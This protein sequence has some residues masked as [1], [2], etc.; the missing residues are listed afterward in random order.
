[1][2]D[3]LSELT[4]RLN[5]VLAEET[6]LLDA[7]DLAAA[8]NLLPRK[9]DAVAAL[10]SAIIAGVHTADLDERQMDALRGRAQRLTELGE[11]NRQ[12]IE[13]G[14]AL[15]TQLIQTIAQ[16]V[17]KAR[18]GEAPVYQADGTKIPPRPPESY[19]FQRQ[20]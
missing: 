6:G 7:L 8:T 13:R 12:A 15:Q 16:A 19:A 2:S 20:M 17:P 14:L 9:Q 3:D 11:A 10:Q 18:A 5:R 1:M 4:E